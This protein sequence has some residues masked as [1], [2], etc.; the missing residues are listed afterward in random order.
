MLVVPGDIVPSK[1]KLT[2]LDQLQKL[3]VIFQQRATVAPPLVHRVQHQC[4]AHQLRMHVDEHSISGQPDKQCVEV[5]RHVRLFVQVLCAALSI[6]RGAVFD[7]QPQLV[8]HGVHESD[9]HAL[10]ERRERIKQLQG[11]L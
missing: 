11:F 1:P 8:L 3:L 5:C 7:L 9:G 6:E 2:L 4:P 10:L